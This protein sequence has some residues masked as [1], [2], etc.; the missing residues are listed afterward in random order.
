MWRSYESAQYRRN[1]LHIDKMLGRA[2]VLVTMVGASLHGIGVEAPNSV[3][4]SWKMFVE[5]MPTYGREI[6]RLDSYAI[7]PG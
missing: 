3:A 5:Q 4:Y 1:M 2:L 7:T 6:E